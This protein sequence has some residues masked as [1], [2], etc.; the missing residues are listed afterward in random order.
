M[1]EPTITIIIS[2]VKN[3]FDHFISNFPFDLLIDIDEVIIIIQGVEQEESLIE[4]NKDYIIIKDSKYGLS[5]SR[6][7]GI[8]KASSDYIWFL[9][10]DIKLFKDSVS[11]VKKYLRKYESD[12]YTVRMKYLENGK[13]YKKYSSKKELGRFDALR[14]SSVELIVSKKCKV[15]WN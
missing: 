2:T 8:E 9:D 14:V 4:L 13:P 6:N 11:N 15:K 3:N 1:S 12:L 10:D 5:R 7:I